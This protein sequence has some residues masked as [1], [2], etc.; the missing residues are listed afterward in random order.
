MTENQHLLMSFGCDNYAC[1]LKLILISLIG[2]SAFV[3]EGKKYPW[4]DTLHKRQQLP[5]LKQKIKETVTTYASGQIHQW[6]WDSWWRIYIQLSCSSSS[7]N[8]PM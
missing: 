6:S 1:N 5:S 3:L 4:T 7:P 2:P 8:H